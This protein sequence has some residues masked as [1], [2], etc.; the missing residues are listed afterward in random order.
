[1]RYVLVTGSRGIIDW[2]TFYESAG[3]AVRALAD[4]V[5]GMKSWMTTP[6]SSSLEPL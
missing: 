4:F 5:K 1:M 6:G 2:A 3:A